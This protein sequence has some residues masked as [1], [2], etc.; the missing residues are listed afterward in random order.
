[1]AKSNSGEH[2]SHKSRTVLFLIDVISDFE[3]EDGDELFKYALPAAKKIAA[4][5]KRARKA[6]VP[7]VYINNNFGNWHEDFWA[8]VKNILKKPSRK[9][10]IVKLLK[11]EKDDYF[12]LKPKHSAFYSTPL[13]LLLEELEAENIILTGVAT[14]ICVS[15]TANDAY[16]RGYNIFV[17]ED[18]VAAVDPKESE[19]ALKYIER[20]LKAGTR[21][22]AEI[23]F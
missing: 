14:D 18:C 1:M 5:K 20:V 9:S 3:F 4:L 23:N 17:P 12:V 2:T 15:F 7:T 19:H 8:T 22:S 10:E 21:P 16:M 6:E 13:D 11:P